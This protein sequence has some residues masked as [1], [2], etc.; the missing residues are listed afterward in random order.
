MKL[1]AEDS[2]RPLGQR[3]RT[4]MPIAYLATVSFRWERSAGKRVMDGMGWGKRVI[5]LKTQ[6]ILEVNTC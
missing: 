4:E 6:K 1:C 3:G 5:W 2:F